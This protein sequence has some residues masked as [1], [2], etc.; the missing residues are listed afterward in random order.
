MDR[1]KKLIQKLEIAEQLFLEGW[2][3]DD[4]NP[5]LIYKREP[6]YVSKIVDLEICAFIRALSM[7]GG[8]E[9]L[10]NRQTHVC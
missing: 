9:I 6:V 4:A 2:D 7:G 10:K 8:I 3:Y 1:W 5:G